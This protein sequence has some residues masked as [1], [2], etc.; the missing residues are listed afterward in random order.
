MSSSGSLLSSGEKY[1]HNGGMTFAHHDGV[2]FTR[3]HDGD[4][5]PFGWSPEMAGL[6]GKSSRAGVR[7]LGG[8][9][10]SSACHLPT[11]AAADTQRAL[12]RDDRAEAVPLDLVGP[13]AADRQLPEP[14]EH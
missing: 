8:S 6:Q 7:A 9:M 5:G 1:C 4:H 11:T 12:G 10:D 13:R 3:V 14:G 2:G